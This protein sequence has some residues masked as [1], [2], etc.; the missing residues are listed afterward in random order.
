MENDGVYHYT[1][2]MFTAE[3]R[4][5]ALRGAGLVIIGLGCCFFL[6]IGV[7]LLVIFTPYLLSFSPSMADAV[8][9]MYASLGIKEF[10]EA[11][12]TIAVMTLGVGL[13]VVMA[14]LGIAGAVF[15]FLGSAIRRNAR[16][17]RL[18]FGIPV[19]LLMLTGIVAYIAQGNFGFGL[20]FDSL[21]FLLAVIVLLPQAADPVT[22]PP[23]A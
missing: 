11:H 15:L 1:H 7:Y 18:L 3:Q 23:T 21:L 17:A 19:G 5:K 2:I 14:P 8:I 4:R 12:I 22:T 6:G 13:L 10:W 9:G 20:F 16:F